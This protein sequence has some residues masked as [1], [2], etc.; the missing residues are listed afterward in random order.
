MSGLR[1]ASPGDAYALAALEER[2]SIATLAGIFAP[3]PYPSG[4]VLARWALV[5]GQPDVTVLVA[6]EA[7][8]LIG[9]AALDGTSL[10]HLGVAP[11]CFGT[12]LADRLHVRA[13]STWQAIG[14]TRVE[15]W[16]LVANAR[17]RRFYERRGWTA[18]G[19]SQECPWRPHPVEVGYTY[20]VA[21]DHSTVHASIGVLSN[22]P[23]LP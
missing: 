20:D 3:Y 10:R 4:D 1:T 22:G 15:L 17:A 8:E 9:F 11:E 2:S 19:R 6:S 7:D 16:V 14:A 5:L 23:D 21:G 12:G 18:D 13:V